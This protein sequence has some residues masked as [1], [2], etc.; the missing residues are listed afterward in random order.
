MTQRSDTAAGM[1]KQMVGRVEAIWRYPVKSMLG[2]SLE[3]ASIG[4]AGLLGDRAYALWDHAT[5]RVAS[6]KNPRLWKTLLGFAAHCL[7]SPQEGAGATAVA[8][9]APDGAQGTPDGARV[10]SSDPTVDSWLS[11]RLGREVSLLDQ[12][13]EGASLDQYWPEVPEREFQ[14]VVNELVLPSGTF[15][16][17]CPIHAISTASLERLRQ[18]E[19][20]LDFAVERFRPNL[21]IRPEAGS[22][23]FVEESWIGHSLGLGDDL[24]LQVNDGCP[25]CVVTTLGQGELPE[26]LEILRATARH[27]N[28][29]A[30]IRLSVTN[31][32][33]VR[34]GDPVTLLD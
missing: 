24:R 1:A 3:A 5:G 13:P 4:R 7:E 25:R 9:T 2:E 11:Q 18:L 20:Q 34:V 27:N 32:G 29:V 15:F 23:G 28:V 6:A 30:G 26:T 8:I 10:I 17:S 16:D 19:P 21:L 14:D 33:E 22:S 12:A 31:P